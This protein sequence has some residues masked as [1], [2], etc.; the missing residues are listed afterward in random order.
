MVMSV[1]GALMTALTISREIE[2]GNLVMLRTT[3]LTRGET[4][5]TSLAATPLH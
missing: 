2:S 3:P 5:M 1:V 4:A